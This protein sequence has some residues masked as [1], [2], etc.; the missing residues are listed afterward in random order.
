MNPLVKD[1]LESAHSHDIE[2]RLLEDMLTKECKCE[3]DHQVLPCTY[4]VVAR[5]TD[6]TPISTMKCENGVLYSRMF[7]AE[8]GVCLCCDSAASKCWTITPI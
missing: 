2:L 5:V 7:M 8:G 1:M 4:K 3:T 6:S